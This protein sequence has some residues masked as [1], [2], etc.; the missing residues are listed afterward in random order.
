[1]AG[2]R[3]HMESTN[4]GTQ[5]ENFFEAL[6]FR[7][8]FHLFLLHSYAFITGTDSFWGGLETP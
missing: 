3:A 7:G 1:M 5:P 8:G 4:A 2:I 6:D